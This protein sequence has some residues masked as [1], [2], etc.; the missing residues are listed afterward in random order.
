[1][2]VSENPVDAL[3]LEITLLHRLH[4]AGACLGE[5]V[6]IVRG[7]SG[8]P[9]VRGVVETAE[10]KQELTRLF[11]EFPGI[12]VLLQVPGG[13]EKAES[14]ADS[15]TSAVPTTAETGPE[16]GTGFSPLKD[17]LLAHFARLDIPAE[18]RRA[19]MVEYSN[20]VISLS[21]SAYLHAWELRRLAERSNKMSL[22]KL[23]PSAVAKFRSMAQDHM[24]ALSQHHRRCDEMLRPVMA[25]LANTQ[26]HGESS[27]SIL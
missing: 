8:K 20:Q 12:P 22:E 17:H 26:S 2:A 25:S 14:T 5:E 16:G 3:E 13:D 10:R 9:E 4:Q 11:A 27:D 21:Q 15:G 19:R 6:Q 7:A 1:M 24:R 18:V 23:S